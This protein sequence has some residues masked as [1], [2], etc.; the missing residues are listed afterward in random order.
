LFGDFLSL[1]PAQHPARAKAQKWVDEHAAAPA[2]AS[3][4]AAQ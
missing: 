1:A 2:D 4:R 3:P